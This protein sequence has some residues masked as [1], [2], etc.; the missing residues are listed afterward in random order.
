[1]GIAKGYRTQVLYKAES[2]WGVQASDPDTVIQG[3]IKDVNIESNNNL[4]HWSS[5]SFEDFN[6][7]RTIK[8]TWFSVHHSVKLSDIELNITDPQLK[9]YIW[10]KGRNYL[11]IDDIKIQTREGNPII[12]GLIKKI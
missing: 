12:Y 4:I 6:I 11:Y 10:N 9:V 7:N 2:S 3:K 1:M 8:N 5:S